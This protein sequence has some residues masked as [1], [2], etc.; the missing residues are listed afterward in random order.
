MPSDDCVVYV[1]RVIRDG[2]IVDAGEPYKVHEGEWIDIVPVT[3][4]QQTIAL[5]GLQEAASKGNETEAEKNID[6]LCKT[7]ADNLTDWSWT[8]NKGNPLPNPF[9]KPEILMSLTEDE[10]AYLLTAL[11]GETPGERKNVSMPSQDLL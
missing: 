8:D 7:L 1:G 3:T 10:L 5:R 6:I 2:E 9:E 11:A 4:I